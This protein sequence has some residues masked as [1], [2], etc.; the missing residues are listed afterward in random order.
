MKAIKEEIAKLL[1]TRDR[2]VANKDLSLFMSTQ[3]CE[4]TSSNSSGYLATEKLNSTLLYTCE[5]ETDPGHFVGL[6]K[7]EY[8]NE[9]KYS[10]RGHL[11]YHFYKHGSEP[12]K[13]SNIAWC[14][15][16]PSSKNAT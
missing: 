4:I 2:A 8:W 10:H 9:G 3:L 13:I 1:A 15:P 14:S 16:M 7:E 11:L 6:V 5:D 12:L